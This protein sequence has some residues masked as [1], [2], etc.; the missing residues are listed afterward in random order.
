MKRC[1]NS[2][3]VQFWRS[4]GLIGLFVGSASTLGASSTQDLTREKQRIR[5]LIGHEQ[6]ERALTHLEVLVKEHPNDAVLCVLRG[7]AYYTLDRCESAVVWFEK[8]VALRADL[9][10]PDQD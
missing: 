6:A 8:G 9:K 5:L 3:W 4:A 1:P 7:E 10:S 2:K